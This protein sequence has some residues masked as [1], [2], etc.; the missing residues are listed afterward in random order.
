MRP[1]LAVAGLLQWPPQEEDQLRYNKMD[2]NAG[3]SRGY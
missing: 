1:Q 3:C 2:T